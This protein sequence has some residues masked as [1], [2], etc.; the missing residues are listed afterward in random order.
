VP[1]VAAATRR[2]AGR[3]RSQ[4]GTGDLRRAIDQ[5]PALAATVATV[6]VAAVLIAAFGGDRTLE[7]T[8]TEPQPAVSRPLVATIGPAPGTRVQDYLDRAEADLRHLATVAA[9]RPA[10]AVVA[11]DR[12]LT[13]DQAR[14][15][16]TGTRVVRAYVRVPSPLPTIYHSLN[17]ASLSELEAEMRG[18]AGTARE[19]AAS[20]TAL[21]QAL[22][23]GGSDKLVRRAYRGN[24]RAARLEARFLDRPAHCRCVFAVV[25]RA[26]EPVLAELAGRPEVRVVDPAPAA[27]SLPSITVFPLEPQVTTVVP[28][29]RAPGG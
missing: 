27:V 12:Y 2:V 5:E 28:R 8:S 21:L 15:A 22:G 7:T 23:P 9:G 25:V 20:F 3:L 10:Y 11:L 1:R 13:P 29:D 26:A 19:T 17:L 6:L 14:A 4:P 16:L 18:A 24:L